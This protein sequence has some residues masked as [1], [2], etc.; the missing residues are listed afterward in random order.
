MNA[1]DAEQL[2]A[3]VAALDRYYN[4]ALELLDDKLCDAVMHEGTQRGADALHAALSLVQSC[5][6]GI[7]QPPELVALHV[8]MVARQG[9]AP[10]RPPCHEV[11][12]TDHPRTVTSGD[13][14]FRAGKRGPDRKKEG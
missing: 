5:L 1:R 10:A 6:E 8:E 3:A 12:M 2:R 13:Y 9:G 11:V 14:Y 4:I 7:L